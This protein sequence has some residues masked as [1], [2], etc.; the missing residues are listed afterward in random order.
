MTTEAQCPIYQNIVEQMTDGVIYVDENER[1]QLINAAAERIRRVSADKVVGKSVYALHGRRLQPR[2]RQLIQNLKEGV[3]PEMRRVIKVQDQYFENT[4]SAVWDADGQFRGVLLISR[5]VTERKQLQQENQQLKSQGQSRNQRHCLVVESQAARE[6]MAMAQAVAPLDSTVLVSGENGT[7]KECVVEMIHQHSPRRGKPLIRVNCAA[8]PE[9]LIEA[10]LF[11]HTRGAFTGAVESRKGQFEHAQGGTLFL[12]E[13]G[14]VPLASQSK[15]LRAIQEK[16][17]QPL[18]GGREI[19]IDTRIIA[20]TNKDLEAEVAAGSFREDLYYR[21]NV[22]H[23]PVPPLRRRQEDILPMADM[24]L[25]HFSSA[26]HKPRRRLTPEAQELLCN[27]SF[28]GNVRQLK[29]AME[30]AVA[31]SQGPDLLP[32]DLPPE[33]A[34]EAADQP[35]SAAAASQEDEAACLKEAL[36]NYERNLILQTLE[37]HNHH[38]QSTARALGISRKSLWQKIQRYQLAEEATEPLVT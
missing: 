33:I 38:K 36:Q 7:G 1:I 34:Q 3:I 22:I 4:Y 9:N 13:I 31:L 15:L 20:A 17:I 16:R 19:Q 24:F 23:I 29:H 21:L 27:Y 8:L 30:R 37:Q 6:T 25:E 2:I 35:G 12:D 32:A 11:G 26:M 5:D 18:G 14:D 28:P 10:E